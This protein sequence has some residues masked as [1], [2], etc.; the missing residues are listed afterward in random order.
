[1]KAARTSKYCCTLIAALWLCVSAA[2]AADAY[3]SKAGRLILPFGAG[4]STDV[5]GRVFAREIE[6]GGAKTRVLD[7]RG[8]PAG[9]TGPEPGARAAP[10]GYTIFTY[11]INQ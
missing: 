1:M 3:P 2:H 11:G 8:G 4:G 9:I 10:D 6:K 7:P 5:V